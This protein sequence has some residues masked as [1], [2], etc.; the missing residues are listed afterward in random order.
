ML[1][2]ALFRPVMGFGAE[3]FGGCGTW[4]DPTVRTQNEN[5]VCVAPSSHQIDVLAETSGREPQTLNS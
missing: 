5:P 4:R 2:Q 1:P 3:S